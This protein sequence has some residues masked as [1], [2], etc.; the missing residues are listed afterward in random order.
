MKDTG[1]GIPAAD[2]KTIFQP[3]SQ[4]DASTTRRFGGTGL[5]LSISASII[6]LMEGRIWAESEPG[7]GSTF[8]FTVRLPLAK[9]L[10]SEPEPAIATS[11][12]VSSPLRIL[13]VEDNPAN[14]KLAA[15]VL[16]ERGHEVETAGDGRQALELVKNNRYDVILMDLQMPCMSGL[17]TT[18]VIRA[19]EDGA[20]RVPII[21]MTAHAQEEDRRRCLESGMDDYLS[22]PIDSQKMVALVERLAAKASSTGVPSPGDWS[23]TPLGPSQPGRSVF[24]PD[25]GLERC[26]KNREML[27]KM[28]QCF[29]EEAGSLLPQMRVSLDSGNLE[30]LGRLAHRLKGTVVYLGA[31]AARAA[32][33]AVESLPRGGHES[34][35][36]GALVDALEKECEALKTALC[37]YLEENESPAIPDP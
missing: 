37:A 17:E 22:K 13:L 25:V 28:I 7:Q 18:A 21:A 10:P 2:L 23:E 26:F 14:Q 4:A 8:Y 6:A 3:F 29:F 35:E 24:D 30:E 36:A 19:E 34:A 20:A 15:F 31:D 16:R 5:G 27:V 11:G 33:L 32:A 12:I 9:E 1:I